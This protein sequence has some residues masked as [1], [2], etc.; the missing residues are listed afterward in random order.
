[1]RGMYVEPTRVGGGGAKE[2]IQGL[3]KEVISLK[4]EKMNAKE[5]KEKELER[6]QT[7]LQALVKAEQIEKERFAREKHELEEEIK[8]GRVAVDADKR[9]VGSSHGPWEIDCT[10]QLMVCTRH[11]TVGTEQSTLG[12][13]H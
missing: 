3:E 10:R 5:D 1:V 2:R 9:L 4:E 12:N 6:V 7:E 13:P 11:E 8:A